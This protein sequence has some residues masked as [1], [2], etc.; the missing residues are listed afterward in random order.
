MSR[1][2]ERAWS[3]AD[4]EA[5]VPAPLRVAAAF[6]WR[7]IVLA[8]VSALI[9]W[10]VIK[11]KLLVIPLF[12]AILLTALLSPLL[13]CMVKR[14]VP[15]VLAVVIS[16]V[17]ALAVVAGIVTLVVW[18]VTKDVEQVKTRAS[19]AIDD[20][21]QL[22]IG[23]GLISESD[24]GDLV[25]NIDT[26]LQDQAD[27]LL[28]AVQAVGS[29]IGHVATGLVLSLFILICLLYDGRN[30]WGWT[31][32]LFPKAAR[33]AVDAAA[34]NGWSTLI[35][36]ART[37]IIVATI[38]SIGIGLGAFLLGVPLAIPVGALVFL[39]AFVP[40]VGAILTG[41][42]AVV[43]ALLYNGPWIALAMLVVIL[44]VQQ[45]ES[46]VLQP[47]LMGSAIEVHPLA[48]V[49][50]VAGGSMVGGIAGALFAVPVAAFVNVAVVTI[51]SG[52]W[53]TGDEIQ[54][55]LMWYTVPKVPPRPVWR[56]ADD[57]GVDDEDADDESDEDDVAPAEDF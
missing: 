7:L 37:Q 3:R 56:R 47:L 8:T 44:V 13:A 40:F 32:R 10:F 46:H 34:Q 41:T 57:P 30:I 39:G 51:T 12:I 29:T 55:D 25:D 28:G 20:L 24:I 45:I 35:T 11:L 18:Q 43:L 6:G 5:A 31:L 53:K 1:R 9:I 54:G 26:F 36:Y 48:V 4:V 14:H 15:R 2:N 23:T 52:S 21:Q 22:V 49:L 38:D 27:H 42:L 16:L 17:A 33:P 19:R 50:V